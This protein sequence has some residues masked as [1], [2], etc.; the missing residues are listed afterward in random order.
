MNKI[1]CNIIGDLLPLYVD[2]AVSE[3]TKKLVE[4]HLADCEECKKAAEEMGK[5]LV[6]P[7]HETVR[8]AE[9]SFLQKMKKTWQKRRIR[10]AVISVAVTAGVILGSYMALTI[11]QW[12]IP[13]KPVDFSVAVE[14][15]MVC[16]YYTG[17]GRINCS[18]GYDGEDEF[19]LYFTQSPWSAYVEPLLEDAE[20]E[21][22]YRYQIDSVDRIAK[23]YYGEF[24]KGLDVL[25][26]KEAEMA[27][28]TELIWIRDEA[29]Q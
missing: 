9:T 5:E 18:Y 27:A 10:T 25:Y 23:V 12:I 4:E 13:Y 3:D 7:V 19:F 15:G 26:G 2:G 11:P 29:S 1:S 22:P 21:E 14:D 24:S 16:V 28:Q 17:K 6:L 8:A 20:Q